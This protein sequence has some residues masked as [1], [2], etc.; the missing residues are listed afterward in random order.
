MVLGLLEFVEASPNAE[1]ISYELLK[2]PEDNDSRT[3][4][5]NRSREQEFK[6]LV[7]VEIL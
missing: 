1:I 5:G 3:V 7:Q 4:A 6:K 2:T